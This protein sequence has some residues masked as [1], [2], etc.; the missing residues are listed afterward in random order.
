M[1]RSDMMKLAQQ[2]GLNPVDTVDKN[3]DI[4]VC[5]DPNSGSSKLQKAIKY[6]IKVVSEQDFKNGKF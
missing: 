3:L 4:L 1:K 5:A 6:G 2:F